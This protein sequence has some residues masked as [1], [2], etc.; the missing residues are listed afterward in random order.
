MAVFHVEHPTTSIQSENAAVFSYLYQLADQLNA[1]LTSI[2]AENLAPAL[3]TSVEESGT[4]SVKERLKTES[5]TLKS[6]IIKTADKVRSETDTIISELK[7]EY[8]AESEFGTYKLQASQQMTDTA[9]STLKTY[10]LVENMTAEEGMTSFAKYMNQR[11]GSIKVGW[12]DD[13]LKVFGVAIGQENL[14]EVP[15][16][17]NGEKVTRIIGK[18]CAWFTAD[19]IRLFDASGDNQYEVAYMTKNKLFI[20]KAEIVDTMVMGNVQAKIIDGQ[21]VWSY[22]ANTAMMRV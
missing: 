15:E 13:D 22:A 4:Q 14:D 6:L 12:L 10:K 19:G 7:S 8:V 21:V 9:I 2:D 16:E 1:A 3:R 18:A 5:D 17:K 20:R 11:N